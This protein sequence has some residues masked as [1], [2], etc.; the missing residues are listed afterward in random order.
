MVI[1]NFP[2]CEYLCFFFIQSLASIN[3]IK[4]PYPELLALLPQIPQD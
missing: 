2:V 4:V 3:M 1:T